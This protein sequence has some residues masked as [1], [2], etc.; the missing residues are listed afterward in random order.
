MRLLAAEGWGIAWTV[1]TLPPALEARAE[2]LAR[3]KYGHA[4]YNQ[5]R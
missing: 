2:Q 4:A 3:E 1:L 5:A